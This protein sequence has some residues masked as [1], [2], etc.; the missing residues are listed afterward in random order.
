MSAGSH[1]TKADMLLDNLKIA[2][3]QIETLK[4]ERD[5]LKEKIKILTSPSIEG[6]LT[7]MKGNLEIVDRI[8]TERDEAIREVAELRGQLAVCEEHAGTMA[9]DFDGI[10]EAIKGQ[11]DELR[12]EV[13]HLEFAKNPIECRNGHRFFASVTHPAKSEREWYCPSCVVKENTELRA[14]VERLK[15]E[16]ENWRVSSVCRELSAEVERLKADNERL[17]YIII[18]TGITREIID[19][20][21]KGDA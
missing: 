20:Q 15:A 17:E 11:R 2:S 18:G 6:V 12:A 13:K 19:R 10:V 8:K 16:R 21:M 7:R 9:K 4:R 3:S 14:E 1:I 5:E